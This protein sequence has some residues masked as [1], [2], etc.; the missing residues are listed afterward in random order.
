MSDAIRESEVRPGE[1]ELLPAK[2]R[3][4][5]EDQKDVEDLRTVRI[6][7]RPVGR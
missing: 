1:T 4:M 2:G 5:D 3:T 6:W 7:T